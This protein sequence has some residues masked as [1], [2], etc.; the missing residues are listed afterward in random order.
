DELSKQEK[1]TITDQEVSK[2]IYFE[3]MQMGQD[4]KAVLE[5]YKN[6]GLLPIVKMSMLEDKVLTLLLNKKHEKK[7]ENK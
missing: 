1:I 4:P 3:S 2:G 5:Y 7:G 6:Q